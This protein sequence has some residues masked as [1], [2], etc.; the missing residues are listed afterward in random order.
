MSTRIYHK[1]YRPKCKSKPWTAPILPLI[2][3]LPVLTI[4]KFSDKIET[5]F[6]IKFLFYPIINET[7][8]SASGKCWM[9]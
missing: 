2:S 5:G 6:Y 9:I 8:S 4:L 3:M 1:L 7:F